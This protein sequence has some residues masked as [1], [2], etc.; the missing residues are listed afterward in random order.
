MKPQPAQLL[1][2]KEL[3]REARLSLRTIRQIVKRGFK[4]PGGTATL[5]EL[6]AWQAMNPR[7][8]SKHWK[9]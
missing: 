3:A 9:N 5:E 4:M 2:A 6:R 8:F 7:P 1:T